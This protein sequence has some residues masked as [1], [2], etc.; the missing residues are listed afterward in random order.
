[1]RKWMSPK[2]A[3]MLEVSS[4]GIVRLAIGI[5]NTRWGTGESRHKKGYVFKQ[6]VKNGRKVVRVSIKG[7]RKQFLV[8]RLVCEA[9]NGP[10]PSPT[11]HAAH[12]NGKELD[13]RADNLYW[14]TPQEN[15]SDRERHGKTMRGDS[16]YARKLSSKDIPDVRRKILDGMPQTEIAKQYGVS[17]Y[18][19]HDIK[20]GKSWKHIV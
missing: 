3:P 20:R 16:H 2:S 7:K 17:N 4:T 8:N 1:M 11:H 13:N 18:A 12:K 19:I 6:D 10:P 9:F 14:A 15:I 5:P